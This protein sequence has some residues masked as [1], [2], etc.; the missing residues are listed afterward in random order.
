MDNGWNIKIKVHPTLTKNDRAELLK[1]YDVHN[2]CVEVVDE[3][4]VSL[5]PKAYAVVS[6]ASSVV[7]ESICLGI[8]VISIGMP[9][10]LDFNILDYLPSSMWRL[11]FTDDEID[12]G[13]NEWALQHPL[14]YDERKKIGLEVLSGFFEENTNDSMR[15]YMESLKDM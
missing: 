7:L 3:E 8:P 9:I 6:S 5:L 2:E 14:S 15:V 11:V 12:K 13:L 1:E 10:G 4:M